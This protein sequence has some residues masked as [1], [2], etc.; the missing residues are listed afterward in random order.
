MTI[1]LADLLAQQKALEREIL[2]ARLSERANA[3]AQIGKIM[4]EHGLTAADLVASA[5][6]KSGGKAGAK[7]AAKYRDPVTG[8]TWTGR[9]LRPKWLAAAMEAGKNAEDYRI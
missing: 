9:G 4:T 6:S 1:S 7:V 5:K 8:S 3:I 2:D